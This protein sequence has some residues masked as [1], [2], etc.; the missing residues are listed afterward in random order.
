MGTMRIA[1]DGSPVDLYR[2]IPERTSEAELIKTLLGPGSEILDLGCGTGRLSEPLRRAGHRVVGV[3]NEPAM[4]AELRLT[5]GVV[6]EIQDLD[7]GRQFDAVLLM[8]HFVNTADQN[9]VGQFL[10]TMS[11]HLRP[12]GLGL[13]E[14]HAPGW[15][16]TCKDG[17]TSRNGVTYSLTVLNRSD[18]VL[19]A[20]VRYEFEGG[21]ADQE[22]QVREVDNAT[23]HDLAESAGLRMMSVL[24]D[25][26]TLVELRR[27]R[28]DAR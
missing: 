18:G 24:D 19:T 20:R 23:L 5:E 4:I 14:R 22:F 15:V 1:P 21:A 3:D 11:R 28:D 26:G 9:L 13:V 12:G 27:D 8:S 7:L 25:A 2:R 16:T 6:A 17:T 10:S